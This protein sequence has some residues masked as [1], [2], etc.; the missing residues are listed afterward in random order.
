MHMLANILCVAAQ[1]CNAN[2]GSQYALMQY[3]AHASTVGGLVPGCLWRA[4]I[5]TINNNKHQCS[6]YALALSCWI[7]LLLLGD[8]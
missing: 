6:F 3:M 2:M 7:Q 1:K 4:F 5:D 8:T